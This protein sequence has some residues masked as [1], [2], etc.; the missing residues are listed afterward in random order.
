MINQELAHSILREIDTKSKAGVAPV[1]SD[2]LR[3]L[4]QGPE[5]LEH[6]I[7]M[8]TGRA[9]SGDLITEI[10][11]QAPRRMTSIRLTYSGLRMLRDGPQSVV[12]LA[13]VK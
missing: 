13:P 8:K 12:L 3:P 2:M 1:T 4:G 7:A 11:T 9:I 6:L 10:L 5:V